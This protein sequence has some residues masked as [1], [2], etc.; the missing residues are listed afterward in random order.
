VLPAESGEFETY[1]D[2]V[3][4]APRV[5]DFDSALARAR[6]FDTDWG[7]IP[8]LGI[9]DLVDVKK[10][11][12][13]EDY[14]IIS[15]L[16]LRL[17]ED[18]APDAGALAWALENVMS[19]DGVRELFLR[20]SASLDRARLPLPAPLARHRDELLAGTELS[21]SAEDELDDWLAERITKLRRADRRYWR[22]IIDDL[23]ELRRAGQLMPE[24]SMV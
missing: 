9:R 1:L 15:R 12:R 13:V 24:G 17:L 11:Q 4:R 20:H 16:V 10:T 8:T 2:V 22:P 18:A 6:E 14:P 7:R 23:R 5:D 19:L 21:E 3:G